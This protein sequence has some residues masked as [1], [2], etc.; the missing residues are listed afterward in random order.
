MTIIWVLLAVIGFVGCGGSGGS[1]SS[2]GVP[3]GYRSFSLSGGGS[4]AGASTLDGSI[5]S[6]N[7]LLLD[8]GA[9]AEGEEGGDLDVP[10]DSASAVCIFEL[11]QEDGKTNSDQIEVYLG[12][13]SSP[14]SIASCSGG[15]KNACI[16]CNTTE[17]AADQACGVTC[18]G[19]IPDN[20]NTEGDWFKLKLKTTFTIGTTVL[21]HTGVAIRFDGTAN[22]LTSVDLVDTT[23]STGRA[24]SSTSCDGSAADE[25]EIS[26]A[27]S[28]L[29]SL[30]TV[31]DTTKVWSIGY[32]FTDDGDGAIDCDDGSACSCV[33][34]E[35]LQIKVTLDK[36]A[37]NAIAFED[38]VQKINFCDV[39]NVTTCTEYSYSVED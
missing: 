1:G 5:V 6:I 31:N 9:G 29:G 37:D 39:D 32:A 21:D 10:D 3:D 15:S 18:D 25:L 30:N 7:D 4:S 11:L 14:A 19:V 13:V 23:P 34:G 8:A 24:L 36:D 26:T 12:N 27:G 35:T 28:A 17:D 16:Y 2:S 38:I 22:S 33:L 20:A